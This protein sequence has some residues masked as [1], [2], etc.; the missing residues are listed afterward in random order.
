MALVARNSRKWLQK[1]ELHLIMQL[2]NRNSIVFSR[3]KIIDCYFYC[4]SSEQRENVI[5]K[6]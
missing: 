6:M 3:R 1:I 5:G 2:T 4:C